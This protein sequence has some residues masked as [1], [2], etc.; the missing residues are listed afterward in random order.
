MDP[1]AAFPDAPAVQ[2]PPSG[3]ANSGDPWAAF[4]DQ[5]GAADAPQGGPKQYASTWDFVKDRFNNP[6]NELSVIGT[7]GQMWKAAQLPGQV[8]RGEVDPQSPEGQQRALEAATVMTPTSPAGPLFSR[9]VE[10]GS[11]QVARTLSSGQ[12]AAQTAENLGAPLP[13]G[14]A[15]DSPMVQATTAK[16]QELPFAG[17]RIREKVAATNEAAGNQVSD[18][19]GQ[20]TGGA[21]D[22][23]SVGATMQPAL[24]GVIDD[25]NS[26]ID[27]VYGALRNVIDPDKTV[28]LPNTAGTLR[29]IVA[30]RT[31]AKQTNPTAGLDDVISLVNPIRDEL[32]RIQSVGASFNGL[33]RARS[34]L[35]NSINFGKTNPGFNVGDAKRLYSAMSAD[36]D[37]VVR[38]SVVDGV[39]PDQ[40]SMVLQ[41]ANSAASGLI[42]QNKTLNQLANAPGEATVGT[43]LGAAKEKGGNLPL[44]QQLRQSMKP[45]DFSRVGGTLLGE[46]G[47]NASTGEFSLN[48]FVTNWNKVSDGAKQTMF[49][50][51]HLSNINDIVQ[52]GTHAKNALAATSR[53]QSGSLLVLLDIAKDAALLGGDL[54]SGGLGMGSAIGAGT[55]AGLYGFTRWLASPAKAAS[56]AKFSRAH[57][58]YTSAPTT[59][60]QAALNIATRNMAMNLGVPVADV[61]KRVA[62]Y[63]GQ[64]M[65]SLGTA[66]VPGQAGG[67]PQD[68]RRAVPGGVQSPRP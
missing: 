22:R 5:P 44:L 52:L 67:N 58:A 62:Q 40:A 59:A 7:L 10:E 24:K 48:Q 38:R 34:D 8:W 57:L 33:Q 50:P 43:L 6:P 11:A 49:S 23:A 51:Q 13:R 28:Q 56:M 41:R 1:W 68:R 15:S 21:N 30:D 31:A 66:I 54:M 35:G 36:M 26:R 18:I 47:H 55:T 61:V 63:V 25:N 4:P 29:K 9:A 42:T 60:R 16:L 53:G 27:A 17:E 46:L 64:R 20:M 32:G 3:V 14:V 19:S 2:P 45:E 39:N 65:P 37:N 12:R